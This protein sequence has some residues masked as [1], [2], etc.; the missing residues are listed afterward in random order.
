MSKGE[1]FLWE[2][3]FDIF[4]IMIKYNPSFFELEK[5]KIKAILDK[6]LGGFIDEVV[7]KRKDILLQISASREEEDIKRYYSILGYDM[8]Y[9]L[10]LRER[11]IRIY[12]EIG[13]KGDIEDIKKLGEGM[14]M[15]YPV[16]EESRVE[17][18]RAKARYLQRVKDIQERVNAL[19]ER[20]SR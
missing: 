14:V 10:S 8:G 11:M 20:L 19:V 18:E 2:E 12:E 6:Q 9:E 5:D 4:D 17:D 15:D 7:K 3:I 13:E 1:G 16:R